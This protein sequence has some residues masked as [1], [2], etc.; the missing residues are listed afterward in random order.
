MQSRHDVKW[1]VNFV[2]ATHCYAQKKREGGRS[3]GFTF[4]ITVMIQ[5]SLIIIP[6]PGMSAPIEEG[7]HTPHTKQLLG[8]PG[9]ALQAWWF[10]PC[11]VSLAQ[12]MR[13]S[14]PQCLPRSVSLCPPFPRCLSFLVWAKLKMRVL[15]GSARHSLWHSSGSGSK[16]VETASPRRR[17]AICKEL[18]GVIG[19]VF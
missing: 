15:P 8:R 4:T 19:Y 14:D 13:T 12:R 3:A 2:W 7:R 1:N 17:D 11:K 10:A 6:L 9:T 16:H 18:A 5:S